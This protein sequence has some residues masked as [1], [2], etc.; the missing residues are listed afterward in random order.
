MQ[1]KDVEIT[2]KAN[3]WR[4]HRLTEAG[5]VLGGLWYSGLETFQLQSRKKSYFLYLKRSIVL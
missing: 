3:R 4:D 2:P 5:L 1:N